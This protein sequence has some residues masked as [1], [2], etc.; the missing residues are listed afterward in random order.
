MPF[1]NFFRNEDVYVCCEIDG[2]HY[3]WEEVF[4]IVLYFICI[5]N[6]FTAN[7]HTF[8]KLDNIV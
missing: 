2:C 7:A 4:N 3:S 5:T 8:P 1:D 6:S